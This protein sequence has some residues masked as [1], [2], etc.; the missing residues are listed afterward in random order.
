MRVTASGDY[1]LPGRLSRSLG[2]L[3]LWLVQWVPKPIAEWIQRRHGYYQIFE[4]EL[5][6]EPGSSRTKWEALHLPTDLAGRSVVDIGCSEGFFCLESAKRG[7][8]VVLGIDSRLTSLVCAR[9]LAL[10]H[11]TAIKYQVATFPD[12]QVRQKYDY[13]LCLS[14]LHHLVSTKDVWKVMSEKK[15]ARDKQ[16]LE[17]YLRVLYSMTDRGGSCIVEIPYEYDEIDERKCVDYD[18]FV[19]C[20]VKAGFAS[21]TV[22]C[23]WEHT[24]KDR[25][26]RVIYVGR[27]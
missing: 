2:N 4:E 6:G 20:F 25:K 9:L 26:D 21:A 15:Y 13:V 8:N 11:K 7:A 16:K 12:L 10:R 17:Q 24:E 18:L 1:K 5:K 22:L 19:E 3:L 14:V 23:Q 27:R